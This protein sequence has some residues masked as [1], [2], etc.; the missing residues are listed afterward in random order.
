MKVREYT[1]KRETTGRTFQLSSLLKKPVQVMGG[2]KWL[3]EISDIVFVLEEPRPRAVGVLLDQGRG[4]LDLFIPWDQV[5][6][7]FRAGIVVKA[8]EPDKPSFPFQGQENW[9]LA[10]KGLLGQKVRDRRNLKTR[11]VRDVVLL[12]EDNHWRLLAVDASLNSSLRNWGMHR[13]ASLIP[14]DLIP[15]E[16]AEPL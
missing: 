9:I 3:G 13:L 4:N 8:L 12:L 14:E 7:L 6:D 15:W 16:F 2:G 10:K 1:P 5:V 11:I